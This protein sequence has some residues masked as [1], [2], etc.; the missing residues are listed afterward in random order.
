MQGPIRPSACGTKSPMMRSHLVSS[1]ATAITKLKLVSHSDRLIQRQCPIVLPSSVRSQE[2]TCTHTYAHTHTQV[3][4]LSQRLTRALLQLNMGQRLSDTPSAP[5]H[6]PCAHSS[7]LLHTHSVIVHKHYNA[8]C[9][10]RLVQCTYYIKSAIHQYATTQYVTPPGP[11]TGF[12]QGDLNSRIN[13][14]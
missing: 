6:T 1:C 10:N 2:C 9:I 7:L 12:S 3:E 4:S 5:E 11:Y 14:L 8:L 13:F